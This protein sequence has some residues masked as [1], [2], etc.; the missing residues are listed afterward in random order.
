[1]LK[2]NEKF[3]FND[4]RFYNV[5]F[6]N[7]ASAEEQLRTLLYEKNVKSPAVFSPQKPYSHSVIPSRYLEDT[8]EPILAI[9]K[10]EIVTPSLVSVKA[11]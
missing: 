4:F 7:M 6:D 10:V 5:T 1:M 8:P 3:S 11:S 2:L 9:E